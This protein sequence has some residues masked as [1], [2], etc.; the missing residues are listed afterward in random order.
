MQWFSCKVGFTVW[1]WLQKGIKLLF[2]IVLWAIHV[3]ILYIWE[4]T[5]HKKPA[6]VYLLERERKLLRRGRELGFWFLGTIMKRKGCSNSYKLCD[7]G[8]PGSSGWA[9]GA[10]CP[11]W[12]VRGATNNV[13]HPTPPK[14]SSSPSCS[15]TLQDGSLC[16]IPFLRGVGW[17]NL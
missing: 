5:L 1:V 3:K 9:R 4:E 14:K 7:N 10:T 2:T 12:Q 16:T 6:L 17:M 8:S 13:P 11:G 15:L